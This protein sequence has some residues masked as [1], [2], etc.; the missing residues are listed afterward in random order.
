MFFSSG[1]FI[2]PYFIWNIGDLMNQS[3]L[4]DIFGEYKKNENR[5]FKNKELLTEKFLP[6]NIL[7]RGEQIT[8]LGRIVAP[9]IKGEK[10]SNT[11]VFGTVGTGK[12]LSVKHVT[13]ELGK[14]SVGVKIMY[15]NC[16]M[17]KVSDT[18]YRLLAEFCR[19]LGESVPATGLPTDQVYNT[20]FRVLDSKKQHVILILDEVDSIIKK[21]GDDVLYS[22]LRVNQDLK[23]AKLSIVGISNDVSFTERLDPRVKSSLSEEEIIFPPYNA[24]QLQDILLQRAEGAFNVGVLEKGVVAKAAALAAQEHGDARKALDLLRVAGEVAERAGRRKA[25]ILDVDA[26]ERKLDTDRTTEVVRSQPKQS[27][28]VL[29]AIFR[30][31]E[32][33]Q[34]D[35]QTGDVFSFYEKI[36]SRRGL[37]TL[38]QRRVQDLINE[39]DMLGVIN[40]RVVSKGRYGRTREIRVLLDKPIVEKVRKILEDNYFL[41]S[42]CRFS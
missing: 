13:S 5:V 10:I 36:A 37:K 7:H 8:Q 42:L 14:E 24:S 26:A 9:A 30:L 6:P 21:I 19:G 29:A 4:K 31:K 35:I 2:N 38:T 1:N 34:E 41:D 3:S 39:L 17:K 22:L 32:Q 27:L 40:T 15:I 16:K 28:A 11:F 20:F 12:T 18:E 25:T 23:N 33:G